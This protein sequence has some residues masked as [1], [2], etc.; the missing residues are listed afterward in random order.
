MSALRVPRNRLSHY[1]SRYEYRNPPPTKSAEKAQAQGYLTLKQLVE[2]GCWKSERP[3]AYL[4]NNP[5]GFVREVTRFA[6]S[7]TYED[8]AI[9]SLLILQGV[10]YPIASTI[11]HYCVDDSYPIL[12]FRVLWSLGIEKPSNYTT[13]FWLCYMETCQKLAQQCQISV[14]ELDK[15]LWQY[16]R[17]RQNDA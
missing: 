15:A 17:E 13:P 3:R 16:S 4:E 9:E 8:S 1:A 2:V 7:T 14:R 12:D 6:F 11:L 5:D 10:Q